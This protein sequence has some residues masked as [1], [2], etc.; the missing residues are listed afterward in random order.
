MQSRRI[1]LIAALAAVTIGALAPSAQA[2][3]RISSYY[4]KDEGS[5]IQLKVNWCDS[6]ADPGDSFSATFRMWDERGGRYEVLQ[7]RVS[8]RIY[9]GCGT[10]WLKLPDV[11]GNG[12]Y[13][14]NA[15]VTNR[16]NGSFSRIAARYFSI[17]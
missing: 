11:Y 16:T 12:L 2:T 8:G 4:A 6:D 5:M 1:G 14:S 9:A 3:P 17:R 7:R 13:S 10:A 15:A